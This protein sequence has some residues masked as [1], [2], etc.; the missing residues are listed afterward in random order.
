MKPL[1]PHNSNRLPSR[2]GVPPYGTKRG[3]ICSITFTP[4]CPRL[5]PQVATD[6]EFLNY[7]PTVAAAA[8]LRTDRLLRGVAPPWPTSLQLLTGYSDSGLT[9]ELS[10]A[11]TAAQR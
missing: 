8:V 6:P 7:R 2:K 4:F 9:P 10:A 3:P 5:P 1:I 11:I